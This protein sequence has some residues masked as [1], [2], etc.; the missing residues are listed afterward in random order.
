MRFFDKRPA[1]QKQPDRA[2]LVFSIMSIV[3][4]AALA[5]WFLLNYFSAGQ[6]QVSLTNALIYQIAW[7]VDSS[8]FLALRKAKPTIL[9]WLLLVTL[10]VTWVYPALFY[11]GIGFVVYFGAFVLAF[12]FATSILPGQQFNRLLI[13]GFVGLL[14]VYLLDAFGASDRL[15]VF[16]PAIAAGIAAVI[17]FIFVLWLWFKYQEFPYRSKVV[18]AVVLVA[19]ISILVITAATVNSLTQSMSREGNQSLETAAY[20]IANSVDDFILV[21]AGTLEAE[22]QIPLFQELLNNPDPAAYELALVQELLRKL[23]TR[24]ELV[25]S[26]KNYFQHIEDYFLLDAS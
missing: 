21:S 3:L 20:I 1:L 14:C 17:L 23:A 6:R 8:S 13:V 15:T 25:G 9:C 4:Y 11:S 12:I 18:Y 10:L 26:G 19:G 22:A 24:G 5:A 16:L 7:A 2:L